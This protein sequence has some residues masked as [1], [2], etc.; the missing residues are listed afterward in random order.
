MILGRYPEDGLSRCLN[1]RCRTVQAGDLATIQQPLDF[2][3]ANIYSGT[4]IR[5]TA[6]GDFEPVTDRDLPV[7]AMGWP[8][9][10]EALYWGP[11]FFHERYRLPIV[12]TENGMAS[13]DHVA[14][15]RVH[16]QQRIDFLHDYLQQYRRAIAE[17]V[18]ALGYFLWSIMDNFEWAEG[19]AKRFGLIHVDYA[20]QQRTLKDSADWYQQVIA[21]HGGNLTG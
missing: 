12:I 4:Y 18:P 10:P 3:G 1:P 20:T 16:D 14:D 6:A 15:G 8:I 13:D 19:Y 9:T 11:R 17:G 21:A 7:T 5:A 2:F